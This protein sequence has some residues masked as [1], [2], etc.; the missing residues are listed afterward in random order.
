MVLLFA[1]PQKSAQ[2]M[3]LVVMVPMALLGA[4]RYWHNPVIDI[5]LKVVAILAAAAVPGVLLGT[6]LAARLPAFWLRKAFAV[7][8]VVVA[9]RMLLMPARPRGLPAGTATQSSE[10]VSSVEDQESE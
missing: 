5:D 9:V 4:Y 8:M 2:G 1:I 6:E 10:C 7:F 3:A